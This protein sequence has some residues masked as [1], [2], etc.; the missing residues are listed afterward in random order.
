M[1]EP[2]YAFQ[3]GRWGR[4]GEELM[5]TFKRALIAIGESARFETDS[6]KAG[7]KPWLPAF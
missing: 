5:S 1:F 2:V 6:C 4:S 3:A 7:G